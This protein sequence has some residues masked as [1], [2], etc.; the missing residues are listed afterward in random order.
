MIQLTPI[1][2]APIKVQA[3]E[4]LTD[5]SG[6][7]S[8][9]VPSGE[10]ITVESG[11]PAIAFTPLS[12]LGSLFGGGTIDIPATRL[13]EPSEQVCSVLVG[14]V[15][16]VFFPYSNSSGTAL[17]VPLTYSRLNRILSPRGEAIPPELFAPGITGNGFTLPASYFQSDSILAGTWEVLGT[18]ATV[19]SAPSVCVDTGVPENCDPVDL[20]KIFRTTLRTI[21]YLSS[22][23]VQAGQRGT[24]KPTGDFRGP[25]YTRGAKS[26]KSFRAIIDSYGAAPYVCSVQSASIGCATRKVDKA[27]VKRTFD[28]IFNVKTPRGLT[29]VKALVPAQKRAFNQMLAT[30]PDEVSVCSK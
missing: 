13:I 27:L 29:K 30:I 2:G 15:P 24:W 1:P 16:S 28:S 23:S 12:Q 18:T 25:Y 21:T 17:T 11:L 7:I 4:L 3:V 10:V 22:K 19:P 6:M 20:E 14:V 5:D 8:T 9:T 26:L